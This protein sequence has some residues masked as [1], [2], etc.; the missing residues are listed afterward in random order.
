M[1]KKCAD[2]PKNFYLTSYYT[3][4]LEVCPIGEWG[5]ENDPG[6]IRYFFPE[7]YEKLFGDIAL[8]EAVNHENCK[9]LNCPWKEK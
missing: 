8:A 3:P 9:C 1:C 7:R 6:Y 4:Y 5:C 2:N